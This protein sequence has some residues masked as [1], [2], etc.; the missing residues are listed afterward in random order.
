[1]KI[2]TAVYQRACTSQNRLYS[3]TPVIQLIN[4]KGGSDNRKFG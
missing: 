4:E 1:M 3:R 2:M